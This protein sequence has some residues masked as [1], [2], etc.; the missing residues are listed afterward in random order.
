MITDLEILTI[1][2]GKIKDPN[3]KG[4]IKTLKD[5]YNEIYNLI[6]D[7]IEETYHTNPDT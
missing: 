6:F 4:D 5:L 7:R 2:E 1:I 3:F